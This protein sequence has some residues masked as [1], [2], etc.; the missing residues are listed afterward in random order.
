MSRKSFGSVVEEVDR[1]SSE[2]Q[3]CS[4]WVKMSDV[5]KKAGFFCF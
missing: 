1:G 2:E 4:D 5:M 3:G